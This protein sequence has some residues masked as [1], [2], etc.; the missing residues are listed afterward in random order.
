MHAITLK[1]IGY[2][3]HVLERNE[4]AALESQAA[5][6]RAGPEVHDFLTQY[7]RSPLDYAITTHKVELMDSEGQVVQEV[8][9]SQPLRLTT[10]KIVYDMLKH[11][12]LD[13]TDGHQ[14][15]TYQTRHV[16]QEVEQAGEKMEVT[17]MNLETGSFMS[18]ISD[19]VIASDGAH[20]AIRK[21]LCPEV[22]PQYVGYVTW[23]GRVPETAVSAS[24]RE[25]LKDRCVILR[26]DGGYQISYENSRSKF[27]LDSY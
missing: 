12:L 13:N 17:V 23:R 21:K 15:A 24:T 10:W 18:M 8:P 3:V 19:L 27:G 2:Q 22:T 5:G 14:V 16:V 4:T 20:S 11:A 9:S 6:I 7:T 1:K 25:V 26:V